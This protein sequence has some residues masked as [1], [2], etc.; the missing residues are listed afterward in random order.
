VDWP[1]TT[2][3]L[4]RW[5]GQPLDERDTLGV[6]N[7]HHTNPE[8]CQVL[9]LRNIARHLARVPIGWWAPPETVK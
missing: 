1:V 4:C 6:T 3:G 7:D 2:T 9:L 8:L 5:C